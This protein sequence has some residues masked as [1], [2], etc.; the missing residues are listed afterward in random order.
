MTDHESAQ[1][2]GQPVDA[3]YY[4]FDLRNG[5]V[6]AFEQH[7]DKVCYYRIQ[8]PKDNRPYARF[9]VS[10]RKLKQT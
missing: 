3:S 4:T 10:F 5:S 1:K 6:L 2:Y 8:T 9:S 7:A